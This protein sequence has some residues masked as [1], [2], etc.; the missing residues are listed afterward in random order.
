MTE[1]QSSCQITFPVVL[2]G[3]AVSHEVHWTMFVAMLLETKIMQVLRFQHG[4]VTPAT[5]DGSHI[6][7]VCCT[8]A[9]ASSRGLQ[10][11]GT[12]SF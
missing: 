4:Q 6:R 10:I 12:Y 9:A 5:G 11:L 7:H 2:A 3:A 8:H 1:R